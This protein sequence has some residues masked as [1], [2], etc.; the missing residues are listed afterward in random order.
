MAKDTTIITR[1]GT[2]RMPSSRNG[3]PRFKLFSESGVIGTTRP[4]SGL[5]YGSVPNYR[6]RLCK[7]TLHNTARATYVTDIEPVD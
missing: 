4:D 5:A 2:E 1:Y 6:G 7:I 3:N